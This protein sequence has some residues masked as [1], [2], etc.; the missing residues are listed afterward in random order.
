M[1]GMD[2][3]MGEGWVRLT[4]STYIR[5]LCQKWLEFPIAEYDHV[6]T[7]SHSKLMSYYEHALVTRGNTPV[8]LAHR[9]RSLVG[10]LLFPAPMTRPDFLYTVGILARAMDFGTEDLF[11]CALYVQPCVFRSVARRRAAL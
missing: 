8:E 1:L 6:A 7:P 10:A 4:S 11:K 9:Y 5:N 3:T 2:I